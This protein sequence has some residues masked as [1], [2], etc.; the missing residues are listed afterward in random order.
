MNKMEITLV[1]SELLA[2]RNYV[3]VHDYMVSCLKDEPEYHANIMA[4]RVTELFRL[5]THIALLYC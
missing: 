4:D 1:A 2:A 5:H 3:R